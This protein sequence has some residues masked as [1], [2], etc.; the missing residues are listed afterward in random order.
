MDR[1]QLKVAKSKVAAARIDS[2]RKTWD[3]VNASAGAVKGAQ[4]KNMFGALDD[5]EEDEEEIE[6]VDNFDDEM[7]VVEE[8]SIA[9]VTE[10]AGVQSAAAA[11]PAPPTQDDDAEIL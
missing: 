11:A 3:E 7:E 10:S 1:T 4:A 6:E 9:A 8:A 2:R 5:G